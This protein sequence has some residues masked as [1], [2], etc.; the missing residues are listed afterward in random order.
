[1]YHIILKKFLVHNETSTEKEIVI[2]CKNVGNGV[3]AEYYIL[4]ENNDMTLE[5]EEFFCGNKFNI[6]LKMKLFTTYLVK[7]TKI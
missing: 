4:D 1:M 5:R 7:F 3:K 6:Y 2:E